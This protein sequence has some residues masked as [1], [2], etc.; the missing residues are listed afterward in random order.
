MRRHQRR[1][2]AL[3]KLPQQAAVAVHR[4]GAFQQA[5]LLEVDLVLQFEPGAFVV[6]PHDS[7]DGRQRRDRL[8]QE[9]RVELGGLDFALGKLDNL[10]DQRLDFLLRAADG[11]VVGAG[12][13]RR[14]CTAHLVG[15]PA[16]H[17]RAWRSDRMPHSERAR[18]ESQL[19]R[20]C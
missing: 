19:F 1:L 2:A 9:R 20:V 7:A 5:G 10:F 8:L 11:L 12:I 13:A 6:G 15:S 14:G 4:V 18:L 3:G 16:G 17:G